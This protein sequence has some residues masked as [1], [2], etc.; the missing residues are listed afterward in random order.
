MSAFAVRFRL[1]KQQEEEKLSPAIDGSLVICLNTLLAR[2]QKKA[3]CG[4]RV[5]NKEEE[6]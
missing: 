2:L 5:R 1:D 3:P 4:T 6:V